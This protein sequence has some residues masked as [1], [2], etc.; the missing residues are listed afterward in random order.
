MPATSLTFGNL[1]LE[2]LSIAGEETWFRVEPPGLAFDVGRGAPELAGIR[3]LFVSHGHLD[4]ALG[5]PYAL[6]QGR[7]HHLPGRRVLA[8]RPLLPALSALLRA[9]EQMEG[10]RYDVELIGLEPGDRVAVGQSFLVEAFATEHVVPSLGYHLIEQK[11]RLLPALAG[12]PTLEIAARARRGEVVDEPAEDLRLTYCGDTA[13]E[14]FAREPRLFEARVLL[15]ECT[16]LTAEHRD[17]G[18]RFGHLHLEDIA[19]VAARFENEAI[20]LHHVS[21]RY[22]PEEVR[23]AVALHLP[24]LAGRL[25]LVL[26]EP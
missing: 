2:G 12:L 26:E 14:V 19:R 3:D 17:K 21:R 5:V 4:H 7:R 6:S 20:V 10:T 25:H 13:A 15:L 8:P 24:S 22:R 23:R 18:A 16:F 1:R 11:R 9:A